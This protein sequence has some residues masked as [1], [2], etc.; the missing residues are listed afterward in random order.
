MLGQLHH[1]LQ[2]ASVHHHRVCGPLSIQNRVSLSWETLLQYALVHYPLHTIITLP[3]LIAQFHWQL[4]MPNAITLSPP[5]LTDDVVFIDSWAASFLLDAF[6]LPI[7]SVPAN[8]GH[9]LSFLFFSVTCGLDLVTSLTFMKG[10]H[11]CRP[12]QWYSRLLECSWLGF[13]YPDF[14]GLLGCLVLLNW[15]FPPCF[16]R[17]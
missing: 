5:C 8:L 2:C 16:I 7:I 1:F 12:W 15:P 6:F 17:M 4:Y 13:L 14:C 3:T 9:H 10:F 11:D